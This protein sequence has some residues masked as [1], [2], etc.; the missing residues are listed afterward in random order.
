MSELDCTCHKV[1]KENL[2]MVR[3]DCEILF[4]EVEDKGALRIRRAPLNYLKMDST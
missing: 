3:I 4:L 2:I 1:G